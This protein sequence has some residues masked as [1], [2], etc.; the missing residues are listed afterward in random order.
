MGAKLEQAILEFFADLPQQG[1][2]DDA[3]TG[4]VLDLIR[5]RLPERPVVADLGCGT[6]RSTLFLAERL[7]SRVTAIELA[8][9]FCARLRESAAARNLSTFVD[10]QEADMAE[11]PVPAESL[12]LLWSEGA[13][14]V[15]GFTEALMRWR[16]LLKPEGFCVVS[17]C[18]WLT[19]D[20]PESVRR[21]WA[22][23]YP[24]MTTIEDN[25]AQARVAGFE[26]EATRILSDEGWSRYYG[27]M[28]RAILTGRAD[29]LGSDFI[30]GLRNE[31]AVFHS[32]RGS[33][34]YVFYVMKPG[35]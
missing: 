9:A 8:P 22:E 26:V 24:A 21:F 17:E 3:E 27:P 32:A 15:L 11:P 13:A 16:P 28:D 7:R 10:V 5:N 23:A 30:A 35:S 6:G 2:G 4:A 14:Y 34:G 1:P 31:Q 20:R 18:T 33:Y 12:D 29:P 19:E 25:T